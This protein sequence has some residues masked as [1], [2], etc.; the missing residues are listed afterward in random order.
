MTPEKISEL[1]SKSNLVQDPLVEKAFAI[2]VSSPMT[3]EQQRGVLKFAEVLSTSCAKDPELVA[4]AL[5]NN[6]TPPDDGAAQFSQRVVDLVKAGTSPEFD[7]IAQVKPHPGIAAHAQDLRK[8]MLA[9]AIA[10]FEEGLPQI[11]RLLDVELHE[12]LDTYKKD[13]LPLVG[14]TGEVRLEQRFLD[15]YNQVA[16]MVREPAI[17]HP[18]L[19]KPK[20]PSAPKGP[21][22]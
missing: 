1:F 13:I 21:S 7:S 17:V 9:S 18:S 8:L 15:C 16:K 22:L 12:F 11:K 19:L 5:L 3:K 6:F 20:A 2:V 4:A 10:G 14:M